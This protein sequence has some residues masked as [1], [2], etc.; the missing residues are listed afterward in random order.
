MCPTDRELMER[1]VWVQPGDDE[2]VWCVGGSYQVVRLIRLAM[3]TWDS[4][5]TEEHER[6]F[7]RSKETGAPLGQ[8][9]ESD[10]P[11]YRP[12]QTDG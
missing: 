3:Q 5:S 8:S 9:Y 7:G 10:E 2:P 11:D 6:V 1:L 12:T 4:E